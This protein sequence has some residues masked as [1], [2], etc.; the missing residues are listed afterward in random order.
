MYLLQQ[1]KLD[2][3]HTPLSPLM[4]NGELVNENDKEQI[5]KNEL[6]DLEDMIAKFSEIPP[7]SPKLFTNDDT[8]ELSSS[9]D[10]THVSNSSL[11][12]LLSYTPIIYDEKLNRSDNQ[13]SSKYSNQDNEN[14]SSS[15]LSQLMQP[16]AINFIEPTQSNMVIEK[17]SQLP[18][19]TSEVQSNMMQSNTTWI[20]PSQSNMKLEKV[21]NIFH[22]ETIAPIITGNSKSVPKPVAA[23]VGFKPMYDIDGIKRHAE[24][25]LKTKIEKKVNESDSERETKGNKIEKNENVTKENDENQGKPLVRKKSVRFQNELENQEEA[26]KVQN[27]KKSILINK[28]DVINIQDSI[29]QSSTHESEDEDDQAYDLDISSYQ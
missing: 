12:N 22:P 1:D 16:A 4:I 14:K 18:S 9:K 23:Q 17:E 25:V 15:D 21:N 10:L 13:A 24:R 8:A 27:H 29:Q 7:L 28:D 3:P 11:A 2:T 19:D 26:S 6:K 5:I 20:Q